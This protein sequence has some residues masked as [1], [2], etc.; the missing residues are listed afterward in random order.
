MKEINFVGKNEVKWKTFESFV[1]GAIDVTPDELASYYSDIIDDLAYAKTFYPK[2]TLVKYLNNLSS[3]AHQ[4]IY[5][6]KKEDKSR[7]LTFWTQEIPLAIRKSHKE[8]LIAL[9]VF[10]I[11]IGIGVVSTYIDQEFSRVI[12]GD[13]Y[14][15]MT[16]NNIENGDPMGVYVDAEKGAMFYNIGSNNIKVGLIAFALGILS[17][18]LSGFML[19]RTGIMVGAFQTFFYRH[20]LLWTTFTT[21]F[22]HGALELSV[23]V[24][25]SGAGLVIGNAWWFPGT[26]TR[27]DSFIEGAKRSVKIVIAS[28]PIFVV[29][30]FLESYVTRHYQILGPWGGMAIIVPSFAYIIWYFIIYPIQVEKK[31]L[32]HGV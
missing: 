11:S 29:A 12:L 7:F 4:Q 19:F 21:I 3:T 27:M 14:V 20:G 17:P 25:I 9:I 2:S 22:I 8:L 31:L 30:A 28:I 16:L 13:H 23:I 10:L 32:N 6:T 26:F 1:S 15:D 18:I 24:I 5:I